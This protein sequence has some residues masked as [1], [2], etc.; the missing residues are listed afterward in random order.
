[1]R[2]HNNAKLLLILAMTMAVWLSPL[3]YRYANA[4][5]SPARIEL[6]KTTFHAM[7][8]RSD[9]TH[10]IDIQ[11]RLTYG[12]Q[13][14]ANAVVQVDSKG[15]SIRTGEDGAFRLTVDRSLIA[16][17]LVRV[18]SVQEAKL[19]GKPIGNDA[20]ASLL[21]AS[22]PISVYHPIEIAKV[23]PSE[24]DADKVKVHARIQIG[25][26]DK[27]SFFRADKYRIAGQVSDA[28]GNPVQ[29]A[30]VWID[31]DSG[32]GFAKSTP[33]D[34]NG[35]YEMYYWPEEE[36]TNLTVIVGTRQYTLPKGKVL[37]LPRRTSVEIRIRLPKEGTVLDDKPPSLVFATST[38]ATYSGLLA[39]L[40]LPSGTPYTVTI[41]DPEGRFILTLSREAWEKH[42]PFFETR[43]TKFFDQEKF[44]KAGDELPIASLQA[45]NQDPRIV[46][47]A[48]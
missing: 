14:V 7:S 5:N 6:E 11:G 32:E 2:I 47:S 19:G 13:P 9:G 8:W 35:R 40:D 3:A 38:G 44:L 26:D 24:T 17:K 31:R 15:R 4:E 36:D 22:A 48:P 16:Y 25:K 42:P 23:E 1:M 43:L 46:A 41:P 33:T 28:D 10:L 39:G 12:D 20:A 30:F 27:I 29:N 21:S 37:S 45:G 18:V 34:R